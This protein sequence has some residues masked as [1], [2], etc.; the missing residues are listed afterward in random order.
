MRT[1]HL[2]LLLIFIPALADLSAEERI[3]NKLY[4]VGTYAYPESYISK[5]TGF[6]EN[7]SIQDS[8]ELEKRILYAEERLYNTGRFLMIEIYYD[9]TGEEGI[10]IYVELTDN[11]APP[12]ESNEG[13]FVL[14]PHVPFYS[15][16]GGM[17]FGSEKYGIV[18]SPLKS[19]PFAFYTAA[20]LQILTENDSTG[21]FFI[22]GLQYSAGPETNLYAAGNYIHMFNDGNVDNREYLSA[23][24]GIEID[25]SYLK[26]VY[27]AG[28]AAGA[29]VEYS[30][31]PYATTG[32]EE[33]LHLYAKPRKYLE[34][35]IRSHHLS[36]SS[37]CAPYRDLS[38]KISTPF[39]AP[40]SLTTGNNA[41]V[42]GVEQY[43]TGLIQ[44]DLGTLT[45]GIDPFLSI[46]TAS[47]FQAGPGLRST[48]HQ[49]AAGG[50]ISLGI[51][52]PVNLS[53]LLGYGYNFDSGSGSFFFKLNGL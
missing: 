5:V 27:G 52:M 21:L 25:Y 10:D 36:L 31:Q 19:F 37:S 11:L 18:I 17:I 4:I 47:A 44:L 30:F 28:F 2:L 39:L 33:Y 48:G 32:T 51:G 45:V 42:L 13:S 50:G 29:E 24:L 3:I 46:G 16:S 15:T 35:V 34:T 8:A 9:E 12:I 40:H 41:L 43:L 26:N 53:F 23:V 7:Q 22:P 20:G 38:S 6:S 1:L 14:F 49:R